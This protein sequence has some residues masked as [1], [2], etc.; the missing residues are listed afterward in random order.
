MKYPE[1]KIHSVSFPLETLLIQNIAK[2]FRA[3][4]P[5]NVHEIEKS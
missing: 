3:P 2:F 5:D 4:A 1:R